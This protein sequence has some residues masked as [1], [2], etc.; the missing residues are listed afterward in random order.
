MCEPLVARK[1]TMGTAMRNILLTTAMM[2]ALTG[3]FAHAASTNDE[4]LANAA[5]NELQELAIAS[6]QYERAAKDIDRIGC[7]N[8]RDSLQKAAHEAL[9]N[10]HRMSFAPV[11]ALESVSILLRESDLVQCPDYARSNFGSGLL[12]MQAGQAIIMLRTDYA[13]GDAG[14]YIVNA[15]GD[16]EA[17]NP[18]RY[19]QSLRDEKYSWVLVRPKDLPLVVSDWKAEMASRE[20][21]DPA[22]ENSGNNLKI[23]QVDYR[24]NSDDDTTRALF[25]RNK[26]DAQAA[27][28]ASK[29]AAAEVMASNAEWSQ[30]LTSLPYMIANQNAGFKLAYVVCN[31]GKDA[32]GQDTCKDDDSRDWSDSR[33]APY[34]WFSDKKECED[35]A[36]RLHAEHPADVDLHGIFTTHCVAASKESGRTP[37]GYKMAFALTAMADGFNEIY[38][39]Y[40]DLRD[41]ES[42]QASAFKTFNAC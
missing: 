12:L 7:Q 16:V 1:A 28:Q 33:T 23:V 8:A 19:A 34:H 38:T 22:L 21:G 5:L 25:Y 11:D 29:Q 31:G 15:S 30:K 42:S 10:M 37:K 27:A 14:W 40:A 35:A 24:K 41:R 26:E 32:R 39:I 3:G 2:L 4:R 6:Q 9:T 36:D 20:V 13:I 17:K 18:L